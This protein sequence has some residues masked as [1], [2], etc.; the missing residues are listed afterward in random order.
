MKRWRG[1]VEI[2]LAWRENEY[3]G[4]KSKVD[5]PSGDSLLKSDLEFF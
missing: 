2:H 4:I 1:M 3:P 5:I